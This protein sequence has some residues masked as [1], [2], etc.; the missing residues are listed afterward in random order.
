MANQ[1]RADGAD[2]WFVTHDGTA[3]LSDVAHDAHVNRGYYKQSS[4][5]WISV[6]P[7]E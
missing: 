6:R 2:L 3:K 4:K 7:N 1:K 5:E